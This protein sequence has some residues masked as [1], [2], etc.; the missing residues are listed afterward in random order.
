MKREII[1]SSTGVIN[2]TSQNID[3]PPIPYTPI[4]KR[5]DMRSLICSLVRG[6]RKEGEEEF[7]LCPS[8]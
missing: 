4:R 3:G 7:D 8:G 1:A 2:A 5:E 6:E